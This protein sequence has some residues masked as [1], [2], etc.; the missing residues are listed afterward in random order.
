MV[1]SNTLSEHQ[2]CSKF[3][4]ETIPCG[5]L[6]MLTLKVW[7]LNSLHKFHNKEICKT[8][9]WN[10]NKIEWPKLHG[11]FEF[12]REKTPGVFVKLFLVKRWRQF[13]RGIFSET[14]AWLW[15]KR[16]KFKKKLQYSYT[17]NQVKGCCKI[18][19]IS[20]VLWR[21]LVPLSF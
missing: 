7:T 8:R 2:F 14:N 20:S 3:D 21:E 9:R 4:F 12:L 1:A 19:K 13:E 11:N 10:L 16:L 6:L 17:W 15:I 18:W 5:R